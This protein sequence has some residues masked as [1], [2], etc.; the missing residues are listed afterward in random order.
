MLQNRDLPQGTFPGNSTFQKKEKNVSEA[1]A[2]TTSGKV[3]SPLPASTICGTRC[4]K[5]AVVN[6]LVILCHDFGHYT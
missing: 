4:V 2:E 3:Q 1:A 5:A 6:T